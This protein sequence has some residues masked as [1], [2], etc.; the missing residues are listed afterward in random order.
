MDPQAP[1]ET[2]PAPPVSPDP[3]PPAD[4]PTA[5]APATEAQQVAMPAPEEQGTHFRPTSFWQQPWVQNVL[6]FVTSVSVHLAILIF[7]LLVFGIYKAVNPV[8]HQDQVIIPEAI[9][10]GGSPER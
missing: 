10:A 2:P 7:A 4:A 8:P 1:V 5:V 9:A 6:P 3:P